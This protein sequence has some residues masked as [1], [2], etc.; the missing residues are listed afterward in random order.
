MS[1]Q[2]HETYAA[3]AVVFNGHPPLR[4]LVALMQI[5][6]AINHFAQESSALTWSTLLHCLGG[7]GALCV[8][9]SSHTMLFE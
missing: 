3:F 8:D 4:N 6:N 9:V 5:K 7:G 2:R 1:V